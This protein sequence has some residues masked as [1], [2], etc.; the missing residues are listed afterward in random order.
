MSPPSPVSA[1]RVQFADEAPAIGSGARF[2][3]ARRG[4]KWV[5]LLCPY[6]MRA[7]RLR[8]WK[9]EAMRVEPIEDRAVVARMNDFLRRRV[10]AS[11]R[12]PTILEQQVMGEKR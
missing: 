10:E 12:T 6:T 4:R 5:Y 8:R 2:V 3:F 7:T 11:D 1:F 9:W